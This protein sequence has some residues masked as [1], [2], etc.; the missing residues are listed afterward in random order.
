[1]MTE[2][3]R[4]TKSRDELTVDD[5]AEVAGGFIPSMTGLPL[6]AAFLALWGPGGLFNSSPPQQTTHDCS[7]CH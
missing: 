5:L 3:T 7:Q 1:M 6:R 2:N 4:N